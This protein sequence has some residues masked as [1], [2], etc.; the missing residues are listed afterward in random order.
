MKQLKIDG[1]IQQFFFFF[2]IKGIDEGHS[3]IAVGPSF[4]FFLISFLSFPKNW[5]IASVYDAAM[6]SMGGGM[7]QTLWLSSPALFQHKGP[8]RY[9][10]FS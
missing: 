3:S 8:I 10:R 4:Q 9:V 2:L 1:F 7:S 5:Q 6:I